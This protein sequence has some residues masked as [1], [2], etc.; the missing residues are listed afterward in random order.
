MRKILLGVSAVSASA[1]LSGCSFLGIGGQ[2]DYRHYDRASS[3]Y[4]QPVAAA[5]KQCASN[6]CL[7]RLNLE[8]GLGPAF[9]V[10]G[11]AVTG[12]DTNEGTGVA[13]NEISMADAY[14]TGYR[15]EAG[16]SYALRP[17]TKVTAMGFY[18]EAESEGRVDWGTVGEQQLTGGLSEYESYGA[19]LGLRQYFAPKRAIIVDSVRPYVEGRLGLAYVEDIEIVGAQLDG[20]AFAGGMD[21]PFYDGGVVGSA[22]GLVGIE[23]PLTKYSTIGLETGLRYTGKLDSDNSVLA[24]GNPLAGINNGSDTLSIPL[25]LRGRYRF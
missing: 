20:T 2:D 19:E 14:E 3:Q 4:G 23:T 18:S 15:A 10:G 17:N 9:V 1:L 22:A 7:S 12:D 25:M 8:G 16:L 11:T 5:P 6:S 21:I 24:A 13:I